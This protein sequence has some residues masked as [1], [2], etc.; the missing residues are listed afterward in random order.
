MQPTRLHSARLQSSLDEQADGCLARAWVLLD[1]GEQLARQAAGNQGVPA[2]WLLAANAIL[3]ARDALE[4]VG[5]GVSPAGSTDE[6]AGG[7][8]RDVVAAAAQQLASIPT[9]HAPPGL[10]LALVYLVQAG[11]EVEQWWCR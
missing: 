4:T 11:H 6:P 10:Y 8:C 7:T 5:A 9:G 1:R 2:L 3:G